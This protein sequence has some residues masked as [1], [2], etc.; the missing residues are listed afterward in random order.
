MRRFLSKFA[1]WRVVNL[2]CNVTRNGL[3]TILRKMHDGAL[4]G[5]NQRIY[6]QQRPERAANLHK[7]HNTYAV[8]A[9]GAVCDKQGARHV[10]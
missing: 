10:M 1:F 9:P 5:E 8:R 7:Q 3:D 6:A 4:K 2:F